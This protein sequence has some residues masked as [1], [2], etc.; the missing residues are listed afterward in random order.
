MVMVHH[1]E[2]AER[3]PDCGTYYEEWDPLRG[4]HVHAYF[5]KPSYCLGCKSKQDSYD[6]TR[7]NASNE[8]GATNGLQMQLVKNDQAPYIRSPLTK[9][10][11]IPR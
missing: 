2:K 3:C 5:P 10:P 4:G 11:I 9:M 8:Q 6:A 1:I 7:E